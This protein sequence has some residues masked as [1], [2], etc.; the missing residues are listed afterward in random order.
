M[1]STSLAETLLFAKQD[2]IRATSLRKC[3]VFFSLSSL[4][5]IHFRSSF[6]P[7]GSG[8]LYTLWDYF[9]PAYQCPRQMTRVGTMGDGG[10]YVCGM[11]TI[12]KKPH[13]VVYSVGIN[14]ESSFEAEI[15]QTSKCE[16]WG[17]DFSVDKF[18]PEI[19][20]DPELKPRAHFFPYMLT[21]FDDHKAKTPM[22]TLP[23][24]MK[25]NGH[26]FIDILKIDIEG[27]EF[28]VLADLVET[29]KDRP[30]PF[31]QL[32]LE[33]HAWSKPF[34]EVYQWFEMLENAGLRPFMAEPNLVYLNLYRGHAPDL[35][36]YAFLNI[37]GDHDVIRDD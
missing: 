18:G 29:Y 21:G 7:Q 28:Q 1:A 19:E 6:P 9:L 37:K 34:H 30:L 20:N 5:L 17:Y 31:G 13:C 35:S 14:G 36:E 12:S 25:Q 11:K 32:Q 3:L 23:S 15:L 2:L 10:K 27:S 24:L 16:V 4:I 8:I 33:I 26:D 22:W